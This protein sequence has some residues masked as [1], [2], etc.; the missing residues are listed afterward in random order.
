MEMEQLCRRLGI[1]QKEL[2]RSVE[3]DLA[4]ISGWP[5]DGFQL[6]EIP[7]GAS[8]RGYCRI[9]LGPKAETRSLAL[10]I[11]SDPDPAK[12]VEEVMA[13]GLIRELP[14]ENVQRHLKS[15][16]VAVPEIYYYNRERGLIYMEDLGPVHLRQVAEGNGADQ[17]R[18]GFEAAINE[19]VK[20]QVDA[21]RKPS[22]DF[23]GFLV[24]FDRGLLRWEF[25]HFT[26][27]AIQKR[28]PGRLTAQDEARI[29]ARFEAMTEELA[30]G[31]YTLQHRDYHMD[32]LLIKDGRV[33]VIDFQDALMGPLPYD[34]ACLLYDR[35]TSAVLGRELIEHLVRF[36]AE[37][38]EAR[39]GE[40]LPRARFQ[41]QFELCVIHR[42]LKVVGRFHFIDQVKK[43]PEYLRFN[44]FMLPVIAEY[45]GRDDQGRELLSIFNRYLPELA[46][47][48]AG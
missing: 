18:L 23:L 16:G 12:G 37:A 42:M 39:S 7:G 34:L 2:T 29:G 10:M 22:P 21:T 43:R 46:A 27:Y 45:L 14:F 11:L 35:D 47:A 38:Y 3:N 28:F 4:K 9:E 36:Y 5:A 1:D 31:L 48:A 41:R 24:R 15:C 40:P 30:S 6:R 26:E 8:V 32:N 19:L 33:R 25:D 20:I 13:A 44:R 17:R